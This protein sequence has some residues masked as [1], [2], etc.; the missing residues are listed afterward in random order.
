[1]YKLPKDCCRPMSDW[2]KEEAEEKTFYINELGNGLFNWSFIA[3]RPEGGTKQFLKEFLE[4]IYDDSK[5]SLYVDPEL[6]IVATGDI[7][8]YNGEACDQFIRH[9][10]PIKKITKIYDVDKR[11]R[12][13]IRTYLETTSCYT[14]GSVFHLKFDRKFTSDQFW[15]TCMDISKEK[16]KGLLCK[17]FA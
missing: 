6:K 5:Q 16:K 14:D 7:F 1:M 4:F 17:L 9:T 12:R 11:D 10:S 2:R 8:N 15:N 13:D 3:Y